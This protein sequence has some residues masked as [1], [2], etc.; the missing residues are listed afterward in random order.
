MPFALKNEG[1]KAITLMVMDTTMWQDRTTLVFWIVTLL[2]RNTLSRFNQVIALEL[3]QC[4]LSN[5]ELN[6]YV[7]KHKP[8]LFAN[9][10]TLP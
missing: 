2:I 1:K 3:H 5:F 9:G 4:D 8:I 6:A 7:H 10:S